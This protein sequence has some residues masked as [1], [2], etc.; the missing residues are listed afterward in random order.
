ML[1]RIIQEDAEITIITENGGVACIRESGYS[2]DDEPRVAVTD[3]YQM[4][5]NDDPSITADNVFDV[6]AE[7]KMYCTDSAT[8]KYNSLEAIEDAL[9]WL[10]LGE[11]NWELS[12][13]IFLDLFPV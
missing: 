7:G 1:F 6:L 4:R 5:L 13:S 10:V 9:G 12:N 2:L 11:K 3:L 8:A